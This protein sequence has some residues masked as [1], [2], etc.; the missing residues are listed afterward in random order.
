LDGELYTNKIPFETLVG[1]LKRKTHSVEQRALLQKVEYHIYDIYDWEKTTIPC[2]ER[3]QG[4][5]LFSSCRYVRPV[6]TRLAFSVDEVM[7][8]FAGF[9]DQGYEGI[10]LRNTNG[11]YVPN[12]RSHHL[13]KYKEFLEEEYP[14]VGFTSGVGKYVHCVIWI[15]EYAPGKEFHV[16]PRGT[17]EQKREWY[18]HGNECIGKQ[19][20]VIFQQKMES[21]C[22]RF[23][24]GKAIR[25]T[26]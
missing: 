24:I 26:Y 13:Q 17:I 1:V 20:T 25:D 18:L 3:L 15:C 22:P 9:I 19:L 23:P 5:S 8:H 12:Y 6:E 4:L 10:M 16:I 21:G 11:I 7:S 2:E 14:I